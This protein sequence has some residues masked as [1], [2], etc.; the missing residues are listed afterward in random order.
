MLQGRDQL[1]HPVVYNKSFVKQLYNDT[2]VDG[3]NVAPRYIAPT[4]EFTLSL[5]GAGYLMVLDL[6]VL[7]KEGLR[8]VHFL[9]VEPN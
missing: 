4:M 9:K 7:G 6:Q 3:G 1:K 8:G 5:E 2:T